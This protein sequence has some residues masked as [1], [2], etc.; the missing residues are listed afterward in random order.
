M[1]SERSAAA[2]RDAFLSGRRSAVQIT[3]DCLARAMAAQRFN[4]FS[5]V[6]ETEALAAARAG[7]PAGRWPGHAGAGR[8]AVRGQ[9]PVRP[10]RPSHAGR[11]GATAG[12]R[13]RRAGRGRAAGLAGRRRGAHRPDAYG[14]VCLRRDGRE[15][16]RRRGAQSLGSSRITGGSSAGTAA[17]IAAG[18]VPLGLGSDTNG[19]IRAPAAFCGIWGL[20]PGTGRLSTIVFLM[21]KAWMRRGRWR[22]MPAASPWQAG[23]ARRGVGC[24][25]Q[26]GRLRIGLRAGFAEHAEPQAWNAVLR[27]AAAFTSAHDRPAGCGPRDA[28]SIISAYEV[29]RNHLRHG[30]AG[31]HAGYSAMVRQ[32]MLAGLALPDDWYRTA[33]AWRRVWRARMQTLFQDV[34]LLL[35]CATPYAAPP[36]GAERL[37]G[38]QGRIYAPRARRRAYD[39]A[40]VAG[41]PAR[42]RGAGGRAGRGHALGVQLIGPP[43]A[44]LHAWLRPCAWK[45]RARAVFPLSLGR[46][47][48]GRRRCGAAVLPPVSGS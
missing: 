42:R 30:F 32:R 48:A 19:S 33:Q 10:A 3:A 6:L 22:R 4:V 36:V 37:V 8:G 43:G 11:R 31:R 13:A 17:A 27:V 5:R 28:A 23:I 26:W 24:A 20:R 7:P 14:R 25:G 47:T 15:C 38:E 45:R 16:D 18:V 2:I 35:T 41:G 34:D 46:R 1:A 39:A 44:R 29:A 9:E 40:G 12:G 21:R